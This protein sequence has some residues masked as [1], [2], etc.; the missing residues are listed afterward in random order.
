MYTTAQNRRRS[1]TASVVLASAKAIT[2]TGAIAT[3]VREPA[4]ASQARLTLSVTA[5]AADSIAVTVETCHTVD[6][7]Y[8][9]LGAFDTLTAVGTNYKLFSGVDRFIRLN[10]TT[11]TGTTQTATISVSGEL[12]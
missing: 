4:D 12:V 1:R 3:S 10:V 8:T 2:A 9:S 11:L 5:L 7:T 6:G